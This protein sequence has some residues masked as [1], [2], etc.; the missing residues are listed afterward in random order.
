MRVM[1]TGEI[2][3]AVIDREVPGGVGVW[4]WGCA[5]TNECGGDSENLLSTSLFF[6]QIIISFSY[7]GE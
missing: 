3:I 7:I 4:L 6:F 1:K 2:T 5:R